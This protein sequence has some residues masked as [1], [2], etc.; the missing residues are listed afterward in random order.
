ML[1]CLP[2]AGGRCMAGSLPASPPSSP[3]GP[4]LAPPS[5]L[6]QAAE[7][8]AVNSPG[9]APGTITRSSSGSQPFQECSPNHPPTANPVPDPHRSQCALLEMREG[10]HKIPCTSL[11]EPQGTMGATALTH[12]FSGLRTSP[13]SRIGVQPT[14][15]Q[16]RLPE[17]QC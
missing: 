12:S 9:E 1:P 10:N 3:P 4:C 7:A 6:G 15:N 13:A 17:T 2:P 8:L 11:A 14:A 16:L 5:L